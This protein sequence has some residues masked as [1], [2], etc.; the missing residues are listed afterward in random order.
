LTVAKWVWVICGN[1]ACGTRKIICGMTLTLTIVLSLTLTLT[2]IKIP[3]RPLLSVFCILRSRLRSPIGDFNLPNV[4]HR[5][6]IVITSAYYQCPDQSLC[7]CGWELQLISNCKFVEINEC[8]RVWMN[9]RCFVN[10]AIYK[11]FTKSS[12]KRHKY[13]FVLQCVLLPNDSSMRSL[14]I[15]SKIFLNKLLKELRKTVKSP[16]LRSMMWQTMIEIAAKNSFICCI[17]V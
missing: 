13:I 2:R 8:Q 15:S 4:S 9:F 5:S 16:S 6:M 1:S 14:S 17:R 7:L 11:H 12:L 3:Q 10:A